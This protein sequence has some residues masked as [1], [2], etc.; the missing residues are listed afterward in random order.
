MFTQ[1]YFHKTRVIYDFHL[2]NALADVLPGGLFPEPKGKNL[3]RYLEWDDWRFLGLLERGKGGDH[4]A[5]LKTRDHFRE[6]YHTTE[7]PKP[8]EL[9]RL[10]DLRKALGPLLATE[11][12]SEKSWYKVGP[13][14]IQILADTP[15]PSLDNFGSRSAQDLEM[16]STLI[17]IDRATL[18]DGSRQEIPELVRKVRAVKPYLSTEAIEREA[19]EVK[20]K[21]L[22]LAVN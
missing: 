21:G 3:D 2:Q 1:V 18:E 20:V 8:A 7:R 17:F 4:G 5:R 14:D 12:P 15:E 10:D 13:A 16:A 11:I 19:Q 22:L 6:I 9:K